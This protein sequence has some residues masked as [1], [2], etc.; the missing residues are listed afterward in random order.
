MPTAFSRS[1][2][3]V[4]GATGLVGAAVARELSARGSALRVFARASSDVSRL[5]PGAAVLRGEL[6]DAAALEAAL[7][8]CDA[9]VHVA[10]IATIGQHGAAELS[11]TNVAGVEAVLG[12]AVRA[13]VRRAVVTSSTAAMGGT[14]TPEVRDEATPG[15]AEAL[16]IPYF[17][18]KLH[19][20]R[21]ALAFGARGLEVV[22]LRPAYVLGPGDVHGSSASTVLAFARGRI[23]AWVEGGASFCDV[24]DVAAAHA[25]ALVRGRPGEAYLLGGHNL[26]MSEFVPKVCALA[27]VKPPPRLPFRVAWAAA[28]LQELV[29]KLA[30]GRAAV[31]RDLTRAAALYTF[32]SSAKAE[33]ELGYRIR[34]LEE[35]LRDT[36]EDFR[37]R[38]KLKA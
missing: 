36:L 33:R 23:P 24:R 29:A 11:R 25:E 30:G 32:V 1:T 15:N 37:A 31:T 12:A 10:G 26:R 16:G 14:R 20:E 18:S 28:G 22:A 13:G 8:G 21:A 34:P 27:G 4:T 35:I 6:D 19:G 9:V 38:G 3:L 2:V 17:T 5:P 7:R